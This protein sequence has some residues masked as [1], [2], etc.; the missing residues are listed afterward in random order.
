[1]IKE[2]RKRAS[3]LETS[4]V[5]YLNEKDQKGIKYDGSALILENKIRRVSKSKQKTEEDCFRILRDNGVS[6]PQD[7]L[8]QIIESRKGE[9]IKHNKLK[10]VT[11]KNK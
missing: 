3:S 5:N 8:T 7:V 11:I 2:L 10:E 9:P 4:I 1:V 6:N